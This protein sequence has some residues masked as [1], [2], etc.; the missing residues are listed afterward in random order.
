MI[1]ARA[2]AVGLL[3]IVGLSVAPTGTVALADGAF[4]VANAEKSG[5]ASMGA[6]VSS[7][8][9]ANAA[10]V[11]EGVD[12]GMFEGAYENAGAEDRKEIVADRTRQLENKYEQ[13]ERNYERLEERKEEMNPVAYE[14]QLTRITVRLSALEESVNETVARANEEEVATDSL[15][16][17]RER[18]HATTEPEVTTAAE[19]I[20][21]IDPPGQGKIPGH[22]ETTTEGSDDVADGESG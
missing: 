21:G 10:D 18:T 3:L 5:E 6:E 12:N 1:E 8:M 20:V 17:V 7:F 22:D 2:V 14:A 15:N 9:Q 16:E 4:G 13:L 19:E 11:S